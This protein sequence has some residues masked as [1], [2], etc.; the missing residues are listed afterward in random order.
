MDGFI[1]GGHM[2][3]ANESDTKQLK[4]V[5]EE[6]DLPGRAPIVADKGYSSK[7]NRDMIKEKPPIIIYKTAF[8]SPSTE[9][10][11]LNILFFIL[12]VS[13]KVC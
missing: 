5:V 11:K 3:P 6:L 9:Y 7:A 12:R 13:L 10:R 8:L 4:R 1:I 2:T